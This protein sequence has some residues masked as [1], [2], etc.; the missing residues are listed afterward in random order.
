M[1]AGACAAIALAIFAG[2]DLSSGTHVRVIQARVAGISGS[3]SVRLS[4]SRGE[5][6]L[7]HLSPRPATST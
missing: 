4:G 6:I 1:L 3:A 2:L 5:L 7:R